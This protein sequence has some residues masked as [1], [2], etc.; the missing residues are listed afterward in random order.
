MN[1]LQL[2]KDLKLILNMLKHGDIL[3]AKKELKALLEEVEIKL[4]AE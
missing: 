2:A 4:L 3:G 1:H